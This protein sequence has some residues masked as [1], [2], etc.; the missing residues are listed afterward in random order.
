MLIGM[1]LWYGGRIWWYFP[2]EDGAKIIGLTMLPLGK[3][4]VFLMWG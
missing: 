2:V 1:V 3:G 4:S